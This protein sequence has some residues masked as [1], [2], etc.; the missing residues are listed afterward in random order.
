M[1]AY[2]IRGG[3]PLSGAVTIHGAKN[4]ALPILAACACI[5]GTC[6]I[7]NCPDIADVDTAIAILSHLG[8]RAWREGRAVLVDAAGLCRCDVPQVLMGGMRSSVLFLGALLTRCGSAELAAPGGCSLGCRPIDLHL[9]AAEALGASWWCEGE[10]LLCRAGTM[11][12]CRLELRCPSVGATEN[13]LLMAL[14]CPGTTVIAN[15]AREPEIADLVRFL[16]AM[17]ARVTGEDTAELTVEG[18]APL[19]GG[20]YLVMPDRMETA[21]YLCAVAGCGGELLLRGA[22]PET[23]EAVTDALSR[24]GCRLEREAGGLRAA[25]PPRL[26]PPGCVITRPY[27]GFPTDAQAPLMAA[28]IRA[29]G[30]TGFV[31]TIFENRLRHAEQLCR[32]GADITQY[33]A[34]A[35][36]RGVRQ[37]RSTELCATDLRCGAALVI[38]ALQAEEVSRVTGIGHIRRGYEDLAAGLRGI[39][40]DIALTAEA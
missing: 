11:A 7:D 19:H 35:V 23:L 20:D 13:A 36:V 27:P 14:G 5:S 33:G 40:A 3:R 34:R 28:V 32:L 10:R 24:A 30:T 15:A 8:C 39:G 37:L 4:S 25:A 21:T 29:G 18:C 2:E 22:R 38:G 17:G 26:Q 1:E 31:E 6:R 16:R 9:W 12:G